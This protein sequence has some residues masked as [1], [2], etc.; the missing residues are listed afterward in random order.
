MTTE[1]ILKEIAEQHKTLEI[2][3]LLM[4]QAI[5]ENKQLKSDNMEYLSRIVAIRKI[6]KEKN[7]G[8]EN[9]CRLED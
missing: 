6:N 8:I 5:A 9:L 7:D 2:L 3:E 1:E 4:K